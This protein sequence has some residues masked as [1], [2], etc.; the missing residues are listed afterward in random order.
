MNDPTTSKPTLVPTFT[1]SGPTGDCWP[2][3]GLGVPPASLVFTVF[4]PLE[5]DRARSGRSP[6]PVCVFRSAP[7]SE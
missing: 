7:S 5:S 1:P 6:L 2:R 3:L 4:E